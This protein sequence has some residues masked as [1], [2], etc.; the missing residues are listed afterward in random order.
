MPRSFGG[1]PISAPTPVEI[2][3]RVCASGRVT[4]TRFKGEIDVRTK[5]AIG[6]V[7]LIQ[8]SFR[9]R[10]GHEKRGACIIDRRRPHDEVRA[11][12]TS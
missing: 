6:P 5:L 2:E 4:Q 9:G 1:C 3:S 8:Q 12:R 11:G 7:L 10:G